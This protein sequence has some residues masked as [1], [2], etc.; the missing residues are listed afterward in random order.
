MEEG[1]LINYLMSL[2]YVAI[3]DFDVCTVWIKNTVNC[4][5]VNKE[6]INLFYEYH[7]PFILLLLENISMYNSL[8]FKLDTVI[9]RE[10]SIMFRLLF[11]VIT[12]LFPDRLQYCNFMHTVIIS[13]LYSTVQYC[14][15]MWSFMYVIHYIKYIFGLAKVS[16]LFAV[17]SMF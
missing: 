11:R 6:L 5:N 4:T 7:Y 15:D 12:F 3:V 10:K 1:E 9:Y 17:R 2:Y 13:L 16:H 14:A 8:I